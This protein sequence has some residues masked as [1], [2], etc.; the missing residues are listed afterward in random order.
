MGTTETMNLPDFAQFAESATPA[1]TALTRMVVDSSQ[2]T[3]NS[4]AQGGNLNA[5]DVEVF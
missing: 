3:H 1:N 5:D 4:H 2:D